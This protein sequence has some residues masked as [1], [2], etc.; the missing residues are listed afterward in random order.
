MRITVM[1][2]V[3]ALVPLV[4]P[5]PSH[6]LL[7]RLAGEDAERAR[8][9]GVELDVLDPPCGLVADVVVVVGLAADDGP[10]ACDPGEA[11]RAG[12]PPGGERQLKRAWD[13]E[14]VDRRRR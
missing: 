12:T 5:G 1:R 11:A 3:L 13:L 2:G 8:D 6:R 9:P 14:R 10:E 4:A 7:H